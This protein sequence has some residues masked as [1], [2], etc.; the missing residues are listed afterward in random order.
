M[1]NLGVFMKNTVKLFNIITLTAIIG[2][3]FAAL[4]L[5][6][7]GGGGDRN[8]GDNPVMRTVTF[9]ANG[10]TIEGA[11]T[12]TVKVEN[13]KMV[14]LP[15]EPVNSQKSF[16]GWFEGKTEGNYGNP[17]DETIP[18]TADKTVYARWGNTAPPEQFD[19]TFNANGGI[20]AVGV[21]THVIKVYKGDTVTMPYPTRNDG[22]APSGWNSKADG[23]GAAFDSSEPVTAAFTVYAQW[24][25]SED[26]SEKE[27]WNV[28]REPSSTATLDHYSIDDDGVCTVTVGGAPDQN[29]DGVWNAWKITAQ[30]AHTGKADTSYVYKFEAW[31]QSGARDLDVHYYQD[32]DKGV[33]LY[34]TIPITT[35]RTTYT[36]YGEA[37]PKGGVQ[38]IKFQCAAQLGTFSVKILEIKEL[39]IGTLTIT[40]F[41]GSPGLTQNM[42]VYGG[43][44]TDTADLSFCAS[45]R[46]DDG[47]AQSN[48]TIKGN[49]ITIPVWELNYGEKTVVPYTGNI[50]VEAG[51]LELCQWN[52]TSDWKWLG[53]DFFV[54]K[55]PITFTNGNATINF[56]TQ[57]QKDRSEGP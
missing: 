1:W 28:W 33:Y 18:V 11:A 14:T 6:G 32:N 22:Y 40:N 56:G 23:S 38:Y 45:L 15:A 44:S 9:D 13:G 36:V 27:R 4:S 2:S 42:D 48:I 24:K 5:T 30:Y 52:H 57:M 43:A 47:W 34:E 35:T 29:S 25:K 26:M 10:G 49:T 54:S 21:T 16:W 8:E 51:D 17:F 46:I 53:S 3:S 12:K 7:C 37:L 41:S 19:I 20:F 55:V 31:T 50:T 39:Q